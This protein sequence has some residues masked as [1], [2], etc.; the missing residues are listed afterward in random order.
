MRGG[1]G[2]EM[3]R[4]PGHTAMQHAGDAKKLGRSGGKI[5]AIQVR[6][7][8]GEELILLAINTLAT[9]KHLFQSIFLL[10]LVMCLQARIRMAVLL[11]LIEHVG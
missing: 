8:S 11:H 9:E 10:F 4:P 2:G 5:Y 1:S 7:N 6:Q 3:L